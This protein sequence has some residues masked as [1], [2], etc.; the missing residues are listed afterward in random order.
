[1]IIL[2]GERQRLRLSALGIAAE[3][4]DQLVLIVLGFVVWSWNSYLR[5]LLSV[6]CRLWTGFELC[7]LLSV[8][9]SFKEER[10]INPEIIS[11]PS[12]SILN[13]PFQIL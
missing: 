7:F 6:T 11:H 8:F 1:M 4:A 13:V 2:P 3:P 9:F 10:I 5:S 12:S